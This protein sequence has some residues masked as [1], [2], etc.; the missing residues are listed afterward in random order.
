M[1]QHPIVLWEMTDESQ[2]HVHF[3]TAGLV[4]EL[5]CC[6][7]THALL[8]LLGS[9]VAFFLY[10]NCICPKARGSGF[11]QDRLSLPTEVFAGQGTVSS[12]TLCFQD[13]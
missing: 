13:A 4:A 3:G 2:T 12:G 10:N 1:T 11:S 6:E 5:L 7:T 8:Q 9:S